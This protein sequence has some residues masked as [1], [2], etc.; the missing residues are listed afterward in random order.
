V[1]ISPDGRW[2]V[3][4]SEDDTARLWDLA[5]KDP[6]AAS[7]VLRGHE[8]TIWCVAISPDGWWL[9][10]GSADKTARLWDLTAKA[11]AAA[12][13]VLRGHENT[14]WCVAVSPDG[15]WIVTGSWDK[16]ARLWPVRL[17]EL[18]DLARRTLGRDVADEEVNSAGVSSRPGGP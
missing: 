15:R 5:A 4:G 17:E 13:V 8:D 2:L 10:T 12:P 11:P 6:A 3:T 9:V 18:M 16:T 7:I 14:I 1:A